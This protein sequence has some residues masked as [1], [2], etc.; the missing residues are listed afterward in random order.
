MLIVK[1]VWHNWKIWSIR[2]A[3]SNHIL[4][5]LT[6]LLPTKKVTKIV[7]KPYGSDNLIHHTNLLAYL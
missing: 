2:N 3:E 6:Q 1:I 7:I 4:S 5:Y